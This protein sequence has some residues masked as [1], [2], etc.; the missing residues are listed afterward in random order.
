MRD[1]TALEAEKVPIDKILYVLA[2]FDIRQDQWRE[3]TSARW[4]SSQCDFLLFHQLKNFAAPRRRLGNNDSNQF[5]TRICAA[6]AEILR[7]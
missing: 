2:N 7:L 5:L 4:S 1:H 6:G 3:R